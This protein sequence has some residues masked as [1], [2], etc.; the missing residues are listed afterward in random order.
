M[1]QRITVNDLTAANQQ[2]DTL[3][4]AM[5]AYIEVTFMVQVRTTQEGQLLLKPV[6][7]S[8]DKALIDAGYGPRLDEI[9]GKYGL[10]RRE[11]D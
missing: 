2:L 9:Y 6:M 1:E 10:K 4:Q 11:T 7:E 5:L 3:A 8:I